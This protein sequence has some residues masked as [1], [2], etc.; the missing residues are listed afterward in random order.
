MRE[1][2]ENKAKS[3]LGRLSSTEMPMTA[4]QRAVEHIRSGAGRLG[5]WAAGALDHLR[6]TSSAREDLERSLASVDRMLEPLRTE[7]ANW[8]AQK[9]LKEIGALDKEIATSQSRADHLYGTLRKPQSIKMPDYGAIGEELDAQARLEALGIGLKERQDAYA[10]HQEQYAPEMDMYG[11]YLDASGQLV[12]HG[13]A[14][15][16]QEMMDAQQAYDDALALYQ[17]KVKAAD[18]AREDENKRQ[19]VARIGEIYNNQKNQADQAQ[20]LADQLTAERDAALREYYRAL[21]TGDLVKKNQENPYT[22]TSDDTRIAAAIG[23]GQ[24]GTYTREMQIMDQMTDAELAVMTYLRNTQGEDAASAYFDYKRSELE[25]RRVGQGAQIMYKYGSEQPAGA[26][27][28]SV[29]QN[30]GGAA[31]SPAKIAED[32]L[33]GQEI[34]SANDE[35]E[36]GTYRDAA[37]EGVMK[38]M[39]GAGRFLY[40]TGMSMLDS[41]ASAALLGKTGGALALGTGAGTDAIR[42]AKESGAS[43]G[44]AL[45]LGLVAGAAELVTEKMGFDRLALFPQMGYK[46]GGWWD[47]L[48]MGKLLNPLD[49]PAPFRSIC[50]LSAEEKRSVS[51][52]GRALAAF[53]EKLG[54]YLK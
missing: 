23:T 12:Q 26:S 5:D 6:G 20:Q 41:A 8:D 18:Q 48:W 49:D 7:K 42:S 10:A 44:Q 14:Q 24:A 52:R 16:Y 13:A 50:Q 37:R 32:L 28:V 36:F 30:L 1:R 31:L 29:W 33:T 27:L 46:F 53:A 19:S 39:G 35:F 43:D 34:G 2:E 15:K 4:Q 9:L 40:Q 21:E 47:I 22:R 3:L 25:K 38:D 54:T 11:P 45:T 17:D 51:H